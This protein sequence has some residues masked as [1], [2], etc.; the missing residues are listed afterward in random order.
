MNDN[1][2][3]VIVENIDVPFWRIVIILLKWAF[4][5]IPALLIFWLVL[6]AIWYGFHL[7]LGHMM[8]GFDFWPMVRH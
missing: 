8:V 7:A 5:A 1:T 6:T 3:R 4:A 2:Y